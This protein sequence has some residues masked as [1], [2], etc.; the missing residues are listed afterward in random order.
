MMVKKSR[1]LPNL[2]YRYNNVYSTDYLKQYIYK[3]YGIKVYDKTPREYLCKYVKKLNNISKL[4]NDKIDKYNN[5]NDFINDKKFEYDYLIDNPEEDIYKNNFNSRDNEKLKMFIEYNKNLTELIKD[6]INSL[7]TQ[8]VPINNTNKYNNDD[9]NNKIN[10]IYDLINKKPDNNDIN[11]KIDDI[12]VLINE[13]NNKNDI[14]ERINEIYKLIGNN[15]H[16]N[17]DHNNEILNNNNINDKIN[18]I[19]N[20]MNKKEHSDDMNKKINV[21][22]DILNEYKNYDDKDLYKKID[23]IYNS[24]NNNDNKINQKINTIYNS[25]KHNNDKFNDIFSTRKFDLL[26]KKFNVYNNQNDYVYYRNI[27]DSLNT[28]I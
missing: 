12:Y 17:N 8:Y 26:D 18:D 11:K 20:L 13:K 14:N 6:L 3:N 24:L 19:Y 2:N 1:C 5:V 28:N 4:Y 22:Y 10:V 7:K 16:H 27:K 21:I 9:I 23:N 25:L 15:Y